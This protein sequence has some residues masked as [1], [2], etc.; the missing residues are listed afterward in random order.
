MYMIYMRHERVKHI[1][2]CHR[3]P[4]EKKTTNSK[5]S[6]SNSPFLTDQL[7]NDIKIKPTC[8]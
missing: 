8:M 7:Q 6:F 4:V 3:T 1:Q 2:T 5:M